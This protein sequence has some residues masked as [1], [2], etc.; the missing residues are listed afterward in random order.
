[1]LTKKDGKEN[2][3]RFG[4]QCQ[5]MKGKLKEKDNTEQAR[6]TRREIWKVS[7]GQTRK[8]EN[9]RLAKKMRAKGR[10]KVRKQQKWN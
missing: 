2:K 5:E 1:M 3:G 9:R 8:K 10:D 7:L 6:G 4:E